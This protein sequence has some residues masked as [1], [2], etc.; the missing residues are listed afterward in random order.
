MNSLAS[1]D[2]M[3]GDESSTNNLIQFIQL[4]CIHSISLRLQLTPFILKY[5]HK[6]E[7]QW[8][9]WWHQSQSEKWWGRK[10]QQP[11]TFLWIEGYNSH[12]TCRANIQSHNSSIL[13]LI[14]FLEIQSLWFASLDLHSSMCDGDGTGMMLW[15]DYDV[16]KLYSQAVF[17]RIE[18]KKF[19]LWIKLYDWEDDVNWNASDVLN[20][21][22]IVCSC[23]SCC[24]VGDFEDKI[25]NTCDRNWM[26]N[27][28]K[29]WSDDERRGREGVRRECPLRENKYRSQRS[30]HW[31]RNC[32][33][34]INKALDAH[35]GHQLIDTHHRIQSLDRSHPKQPRRSSKEMKWNLIREGVVG[36][37]G[38]GKSLL[39]F[40][41]ALPCHAP[42]SQWL[43][44]AD[45]KNTRMNDECLSSEIM[46]KRDRGL[47]QIPFANP[48]RNGWEAAPVE[49]KLVL[50]TAF[51]EGRR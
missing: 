31:W 27:N 17:G 14:N 25:R 36:W 47:H 44:R 19:S 6:A 49:R 32:W 37:Q 13:E 30:R 16:G 10:W 20:I 7:Q 48:P 23:S 2:A 24:S 43:K 42:V 34:K 51:V 28:H 35:W 45:L 22:I 50:T 8:E 4:H 41:S 38:R 29:L 26:P 5:D 33:A 46:N 9:S 12:P 39:F 40:C 18:G 21:P 3:R 11:Q 1:C 15:H